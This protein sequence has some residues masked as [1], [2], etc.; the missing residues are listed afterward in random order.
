MT[1]EPSI[2]SETRPGAT[3]APRKLISLLAISL[4]M[5]ALA[6]WALRAG[7]LPVLPP[8]DAWVDVRPGWVFGYA[9]LWSVV[10]M[11]RSSRWVALLAPHGQVSMARVTAIGLVGLGALIVFPMRLGELVR[12]V[13]VRRYESVSTWT[14]FGTVAAERIIDGLFLSCSLLLAMAL[15]PVTQTGERLGPYAVSPAW[16]AGIVRG[17]F[18]IFAVGLLGL[19]VAYWRRDLA[20]KILARVLEPFSPRAAAWGIG[21]MDRL[22]AGL[23]FLPHRRHLATFLGL[24]AAYWALNGIG[25]WVLATACGLDLTLAQAWVVLGLLALGVLVPNAPGYFGVFQL[26]TFIGLSLYVGDVT[27]ARSGAAFV[28]LLY[29]I[30]VGGTVLFA[31]AAWLGLRFAGAVPAQDGAS[32]RA[33]PLLDRGVSG[34]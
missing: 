23:A 34:T 20:T 10:L 17:A 27:L 32:R 30:Q 28:M 13:L 11:L 5:A 1:P 19:V 12:P 9:L 29:S 8:A 6:V 24:T 3:P 7:A 21:V 18:A 31:L 2:G 14:A 16:V 22:I 15:A 33:E 26:S 4:V 25:M